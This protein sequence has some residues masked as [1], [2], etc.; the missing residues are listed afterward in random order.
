MSAD[1]PFDADPPPAWPTGAAFTPPRVPC[2]GE[3]LG[4]EAPSRHGV[5]RVCRK[6]SASD[7]SRRHASSAA[8]VGAPGCAPFRA[9]GATRLPGCVLQTVPPAT[10]VADGF[11]LV[12]RRRGSK[13]AQSET[14]GRA[15]EQGTQQGKG[16]QQRGQAGAQS[17]ARLEPESAAWHPMTSFRRIF[18]APHRDPRYRRGGDLIGPGAKPCPALVAR[19]RP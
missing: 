2:D 1:Q 8:S 7:V 12:R 18:G 9:E 13:M 3:C 14:Q 5:R 6:R 4:G 11:T 15:Q 16:G 10:T 19:A 17:P